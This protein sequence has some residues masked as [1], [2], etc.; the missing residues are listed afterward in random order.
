[1]DVIEAAK[2]RVAYL[3]AEARKW[4]DFVDQAN[5]LASMPVVTATSHLVLGPSRSGAGGANQRVRSAPK[6]GV[7][8]ETAEAAKM[9]MS[10]GMEGAK[11]RDLL[12]K[13]EAMNIE[14]GGQNPVATLSARL[15]GSQM[16]RQQGGRWYLKPDIA[17]QTT[18]AADSKREVVVGDLGFGASPKPIL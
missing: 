15:S 8:V 14:I 2:Q 18:P 3:L 7:V 13:L 6:S 1:M 10:G 4:Q 16:F 12:P 11:T 9:L 5:E 17:H